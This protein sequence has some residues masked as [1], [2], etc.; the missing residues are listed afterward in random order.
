VRR[1]VLTARVRLCKPQQNSREIRT[2]KSLPGRNPNPSDR[3]I[4]YDLVDHFIIGNE[5]SFHMAWVD[6]GS[7]VPE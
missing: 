7:R 2:Q 1:C 5:V 3:K 6:T 4:D